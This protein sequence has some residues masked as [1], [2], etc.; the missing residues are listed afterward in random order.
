MSYPN[1]W[2]L[3]CD[4]QEDGSCDAQARCQKLPP[5]NPHHAAQPWVTERGRAWLP[6]VV[7]AAHSLR[8]FHGEEPSGCQFPPLPFLLRPGLHEGLSSK[9]PSGPGLAL[10]GSSMQSS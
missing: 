10:G 3:E 4:E 7:E 8:Q 6:G 9:G 2:Y 1:A 5:L